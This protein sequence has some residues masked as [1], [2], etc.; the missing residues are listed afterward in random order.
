MFISKERLHIITEKN[1]E[2]VPDLIIEIISPS[3]EYRDRVIKRKLYGKYGV[4]EY[5]L[6]DPERRIGP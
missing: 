2:G 4:R 3:S 1:I 5:W 6:V